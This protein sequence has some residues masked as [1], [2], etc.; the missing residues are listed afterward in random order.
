MLLLRD[1]KTGGVILSGAATN[2]GVHP[3]PLPR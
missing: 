1:R 3:C 2:E